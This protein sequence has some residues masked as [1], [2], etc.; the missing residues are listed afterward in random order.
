MTMLPYLKKSSTQCLFINTL[1]PFFPVF[2]NLEIN[3]QSCDAYGGPPGMMSCRGASEAATEVTS[4]STSRPNSVHTQM[5]E[6][7]DSY[8]AAAASVEAAAGKPEV[9]GKGGGN[10]TYLT[11][12][13]CEV[14]YYDGDTASELEKHFTRSL[15]AESND[16]GKIF[17]EINLLK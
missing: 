11:T 13:V 15:N 5:V 4:P 12:N 6:R 9:A 8:E 10:A 14:K 16:K 3:P 7:R 17:R 1:H 2:Q